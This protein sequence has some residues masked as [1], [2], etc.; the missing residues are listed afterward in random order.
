VAGAPLIAFR[1]PT[2]GVRAQIARDAARDPT[3]PDLSHPSLRSWLDTLPQGHGRS[4][5]FETRLRWSPGGATGSIDKGLAHAG[6]RPLAKPAKF[7]VTGKYG[8]LRDGEV[9]RARAWG[10]ELARALARPVEPV[11]PS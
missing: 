6:Y 10:T 8:P 1:L 2:E 11:R 4:A 5:A 3:P 7:I 9:E